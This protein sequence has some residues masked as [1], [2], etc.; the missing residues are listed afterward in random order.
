M[1]NL[2][3]TGPMG[4]GPMTGRRLGRCNSKKT[5]APDKSNKEDEMAYGAGRGGRPWGG[6]QGRCFGGGRWKG[7][8]RRRGFGRNQT[9]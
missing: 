8:G 1:P 4:Q 9:T 5:E 6:A 2:N 3:R 7:W